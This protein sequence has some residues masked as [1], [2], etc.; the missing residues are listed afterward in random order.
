MKVGKDEI[1]SN[2]PSVLLSNGDFIFTTFHNYYR[3]M[4]L[5]NNV[6]VKIRV[7]YVDPLNEDWRNHEKWKPHGY[8]LSNFEGARGICIF[9]LFFI[10]LIFFPCQFNNTVV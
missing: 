1:V 6:G 7:G 10:I 2:V 8:R 9:Q 3:K 5:T 4:V